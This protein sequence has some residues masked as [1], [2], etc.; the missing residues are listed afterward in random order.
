ME[1]Q[2]REF[3]FYKAKFKRLPCLPHPEFIWNL[4]LLC[5]LWFSK[6]VYSFMWCIFDHCPCLRLCVDQSREP[7]DESQV[8]L[9]FPILH[10][11]QYHQHDMECVH[12]DKLIFPSFSIQLRFP[13][14]CH[15]DH[16]THLN[17]PSPRTA[18]H[19][20]TPFPRTQMKYYRMPPRKMDIKLL[21]LNY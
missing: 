11:H 20:A 17:S 13:M 19:T 9:Y 3:Y 14:I 21:L 18:L 6:H 1:S 8:T 2:R 15:T 5:T 7:K 4:T 12:Q 10:G 16:Q